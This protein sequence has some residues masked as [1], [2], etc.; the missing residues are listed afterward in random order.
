MKQPTATKVML[1]E[2]VDGLPDDLPIGVY[3]DMGTVISWMADER[4]EW[5][6]GG[7]NER[8]EVSQH[9]WYPAKRRNFVIFEPG[10]E[11]L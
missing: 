10:Q 2:L 9:P 5:S 11:D 3:V 1:Q 8:G 6:Q 4:R 7:T